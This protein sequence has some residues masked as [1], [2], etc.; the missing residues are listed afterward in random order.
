MAS[1]FYRALHEYSFITPEL[2]KN[3]ADCIV[4]YAGLFRGQERY[5]KLL[6]IASAKLEMGLTVD[7]TM[8]DDRLES[9]LQ[10]QG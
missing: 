5:G 9:V 1:E 4:S 2:Y 3:W 10:R 7:D 8:Y 6:E